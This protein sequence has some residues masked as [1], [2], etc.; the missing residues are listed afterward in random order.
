MLG[1]VRVQSLQID[2]PSLSAWCFPPVAQAFYAGT[3]ARPDLSQE[4]RTDSWI[5]LTKQDT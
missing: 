5:D 1:T 2:L 3:V 4:L